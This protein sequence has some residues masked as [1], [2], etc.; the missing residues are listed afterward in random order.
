VT[1]RY[2]DHLCWNSSKIISRLVSLG[3]LLLW[4][5]SK[6]NTQN[7]DQNR[8]GVWKSGLR[9]T[10]ALISL[11]HGKRGP[12]LLWRSNRKSCLVKM[13]SLAISISC[14]K[15]VQDDVCYIHATDKIC[16]C[17]YYHN[18]STNQLYQMTDNLHWLT[19]IVS[20]SSCNDAVSHLS[21]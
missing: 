10:K 9:H 17:Y 1:L 5:Y 16:Y 19:N 3:C 12:S 18:L 15:H 13:M 21:A 11:K 7:F 8:G 20:T 14:Q 6:G 2:P 4:I